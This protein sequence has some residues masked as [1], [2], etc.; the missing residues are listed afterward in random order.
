MGE[1]FASRFDYSGV[2][3]LLRCPDTRENRLGVNPE[4]QKR[5]TRKGLRIVN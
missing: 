3:G 4:K 2:R 5:A 1:I